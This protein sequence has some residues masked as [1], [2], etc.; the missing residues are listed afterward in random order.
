MKDLLRIITL[1][2]IEILK[3]A[4]YIYFRFEFGI[5]INLYIKYEVWNSYAQ[6]FNKIDYRI[7]V[8]IAMSY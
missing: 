7:S 3:F 8:K 6:L 4:N 1:K 2:H 5:S